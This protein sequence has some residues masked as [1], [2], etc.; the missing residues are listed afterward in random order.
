MIPECMPISASVNDKQKQYVTNRICDPY[1][2]PEY[3]RLI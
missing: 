3:T 1:D 2:N